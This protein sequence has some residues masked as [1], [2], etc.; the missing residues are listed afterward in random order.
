MN[1]FAGFAASFL[2]FTA[3]LWG[4]F[5][6]HHPMPFPNLPFTF[7]TSTEEGTS[8]RPDFGGGNGHPP[9]PP[10]FATSTASTSTSTRPFRRFPF[11]TSTR[12]FGTTTRPEGTSTRPWGTSTPPHGT[13]TAPHKFPPRFPLPPFIGSSTENHDGKGFP[14]PPFTTQ[15]TTQGNVQGNIHINVTGS[16]GNVQ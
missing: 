6:G 10:H 3:G 1:N 14:P 2:A 13:S 4:M 12:P 15:P 11:G 7:A 16:Q 8:T 9:F 5:T